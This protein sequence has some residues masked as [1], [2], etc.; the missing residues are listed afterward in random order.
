MSAKASGL[1]EAAELYHAETITFPL[2]LA[3]Y[4]ELRYRHLVVE[5]RKL[6][7]GANSP[8][9]PNLRLPWAEG[10]DLLSGETMLV[11]YELVHTNYTIPPPEGHGCFYATSN[12][13]ASGND[14]LK[15]SPNAFT[16]RQS[17]ALD[18]SEL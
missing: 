2:R 4:E 12:G 11:P 15:A 7:R 9:H 10:R 1:M 14:P 18:V 13:L 17:K 6:P 16:I 8:F 3:S 5:P